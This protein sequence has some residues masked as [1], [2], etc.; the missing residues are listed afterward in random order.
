MS[1]R[2]ITT[3]SGGE[4]I[5][6]PLETKASAL[7]FARSLQ[8]DGISVLR[9]EGSDGDVVLMHAIGSDPLDSA[10]AGRRRKRQPPQQTAP[11]GRWNR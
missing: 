2:V 5:S 3:A 4:D 11:A 1:W 7:E 8:A 10:Q 6:A 9:L